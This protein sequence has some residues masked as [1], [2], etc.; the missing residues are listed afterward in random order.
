MME[1]CSDKLR[2]YELNPGGW[3]H[4][5]EVSRG[6]KVSFIT[7]WVC[8]DTHETC[9][10]MVEHVM[11]R[12][13]LNEHDPDIFHADDETY[14]WV[15]ERYPGNERRHWRQHFHW[16]YPKDPGGQWAFDLFTDL[17]DALSPQLQDEVLR[18]LPAP[19]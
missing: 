19:S 2:F 3:V 5:V 13:D 8:S 9:A 6:A 10:P 15:D 4:T 17:G 14:R 18:H 16:R 1:V 7:L 12:P 11:D